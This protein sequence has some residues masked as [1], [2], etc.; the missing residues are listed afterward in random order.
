MRALNEWYRDHHQANMECLQTYKK[1]LLV[2][3]FRNTCFL[4]KYP[5]LLQVPFLLEKLTKLGMNIDHSIESKEERHLSAMTETLN[6]Y[7][8]LQKH[9]GKDQTQGRLNN[10]LKNLASKRNS[11][12]RKWLNR[13]LT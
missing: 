11:V 2:L 7:A 12:H 4:Q 6:S 8:P 9:R 3:L 13:E 1:D 5:M 10:R